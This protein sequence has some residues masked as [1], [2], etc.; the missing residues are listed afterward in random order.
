MNLNMDECFTNYIGGKQN[1]CIFCNNPG[2]IYSKISS[3]NKV[4]IISFKRNNHNF[5]CDI[6]FGAKLNIANYCSKDNM[7][8]INSNTIYNLKAVI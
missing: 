8:G 2:Y 3:P 5:N 4:L 1:N 7:S 6:D